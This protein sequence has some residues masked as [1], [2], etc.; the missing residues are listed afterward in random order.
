L[1]NDLGVWP[2]SL[3]FRLIR[4]CAVKIRRK[5]EALPLPPIMK[6]YLRS[7]KKI[8]MSEK[9][10]GI[11]GGNKRGEERLMR[12]KTCMQLEK[13][14][15]PVFFRIRVIVFPLF[16]CLPLLFNDR[17]LRSA[18]GATRCVK[19]G[20]RCEKRRLLLPYRDFTQN[21]FGFRIFYQQYDRFLRGT[22]R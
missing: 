14:R 17:P 21:V 16:S 2:V 4:V 12:E 7:W 11:S 15:T 5:P 22:I 20:R 19:K 9:S 10:T 13:D 1:G 8:L 18:V 6:P 3:F